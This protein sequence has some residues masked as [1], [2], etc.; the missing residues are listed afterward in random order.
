MSGNVFDTNV[1]VY[2]A[3]SDPVNADRAEAVI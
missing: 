3:P 2:I 1:L